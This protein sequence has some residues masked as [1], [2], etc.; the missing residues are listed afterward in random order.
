MI[1]V[2]T[3]AT[4]S[5]M[6]VSWARLK[7]GE[8]VPCSRWKCL[9]TTNLTDVVTDIIDWAKFADPACTVIP[10]FLNGFTTA[11]FDI[12]VR[13]KGF[14]VNC[15]RRLV[16]GLFPLNPIAA[17]FGR[18]YDVLVTIAAEAPGVARSLIEQIRGKYA[19]EI[20][21]DS[22]QSAGADG[23]DAAAQP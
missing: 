10:L 17:E 5:G 13:G 15:G 2:R 6:L 1:T 19:C 23:E 9:L 7:K 20:Q 12:A 18:N 4:G 22:E 16:R 8:L 14:Q 3:R 11:S 21:L